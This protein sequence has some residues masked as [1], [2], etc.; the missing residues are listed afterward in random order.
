[1]MVYIVA[2]NE[3]FQEREEL[4]HQL[5]SLAG[6]K[7]CGIGKDGY[8]AV[9]LVDVYKPDIALIDSKINVYVHTGLLH[10]LK[11]IS[12]STAIALMVSAED[13]IPVH[14]MIDETPAACLLKDTDMDHLE[15]IIKEVYS[16]RLYINP[17]I[18]VKT[19]CIL[20]DRNKAAGSE[21]R[22]EGKKE[23]PRLAEL[24]STEIRIFAYVA[25]GRSNNEI[26]GC[27]KLKN[28]TVR[29]YISTAMRKAGL[30]NRVEIAFYAREN[31]LT[32]IY[33]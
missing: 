23:T 20:A 26:A 17:A 16:G 28:G 14:W 24:N 22:W 7:L 33:R 25:E 5:A 3:K 18:A 12:P 31:G 21:T 29:N 32:G 15:Y 4:K 6:V 19:F 10:L 27:L 13:V 30:K 9:R 1:M 11:R 2:I 8:D